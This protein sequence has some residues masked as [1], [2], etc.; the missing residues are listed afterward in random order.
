MLAGTVV[1]VNAGTQLAQLESLSGIVS[2]GLLAS[3]VLLGIFPLIAKKIVDLVQARRV[4]AGWQKP[5]RFDRNLVVIGAGAAG[6]VTSYIAAAVKAK[7]TLVEKH[8]MGGD[9][10]NT[11][12]VPSKA[13]IRSARLLSQMARSQNYGIASARAEFSFAEVMERVQRVIQDIAPHD[14]IERYTGLG[15]E[16]IEGTAK[17]VSP[18][19]VDITRA[20]GSMQRL[21]TRSIVIATGARPFVPPIPGLAEVGCLTSDTVWNLRELP[22]APGRPR[23]R[24]DR[25]RTGADLRPPRQPGDAGRNGT[26]P[27]AAR[28]S[29]G[30]RTGHAAFH[31]RRHEACGQPRGAA[32][33]CR[34]RREDP[35]RRT[36]RPGSAHPLRRSA[37]RRRPRRQSQRLRAGRTRHSGRQDGGNQRIPADAL[38]QY[39][40]RR[41][42]RRALPVHP[43][44][45]AS[46]LVRGG[47]C[48]VRSVQ[49]IQGRL[50]GDPVGDLHR[51]GSRARRPERTGGQGT[52]ASPTKSASTAST[53]STAPLPTARRTASSRC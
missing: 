35:D 9:C 16:V 11:G 29:R 43:H 40:R 22:Q 47:Q 13:L 26:A 49:E 21:S 18:W 1:Y 15:V 53:I 46:G 31:R 39:L 7:V 30:F 32:L 37:G 36:R 6:L 14:S 19:E 33:S 28:R 24:A 50:L 4:Y 51:A 34:E 45:R 27:L 38:P 23:R 8:K 20:D 48:A 5:A 44:R 52:R 25:L 10:L 42:C 17:I 3:F 2:P 41:R 12:C